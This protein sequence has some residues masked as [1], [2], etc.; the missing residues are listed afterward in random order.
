MSSNKIAKALIFIVLTFS[1][2]G[3]SKGGE[4]SGQDHY[5]DP[6]Q[7]LLNTKRAILDLD[8]ALVE[9]LISQIDVN[10]RL[11]DHSTLLA[12]AV[13]T[14]EP[15]LVKLLLEKGAIAQPMA[16]ENATLETISNR[17]T[18]II[19]ACRYGNSAILNALLDSGVDPNSSI[20]DGTSAFQLCAGSASAE[21]LARM[22][23]LGATVT[24]ENNKG[25]TALMWA[26]NYGRVANLNYLID[27]GAAINRQT[28]EGY[29]A[30]FFAIKS[31]NLDAVKTMVS[32]GADLFTRAQDGT[33]AA[34]LGVYTKNYVFLTWFVEEMHSLMNAEAKDTVLTAFDRDGYQLL[35]AAVKANQPAL[36]SALLSVGANPH[37][38]SEPS[39]LTWRYEANFKTEDYIP[40]QLSAI[41]LAETNGLDA[42]ALLLHD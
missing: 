18:P 1:Y 29:S 38:V 37:T 5:V 23:S 26:A 12:W 8:L 36:V 30:L 20:D 2:L 39:T 4:P 19:Q 40:P 33:T 17:F 6:Q 16:T 21:D 42:I 31:H 22:V 15:A 10:K 24:A 35:H 14:Q 34:Q 25:Q 9:T 41:E 7:L 27:E 32:Q 13:E 28:Q 3:C 11:P